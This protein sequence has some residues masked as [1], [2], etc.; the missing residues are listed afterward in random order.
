MTD[1]L[2][3]VFTRK[4]L[5]PFLR[6]TTQDIRNEIRAVA[7]LCRAGKNEYMVPVF[8]CGKLPIGDYYFIDMELC[9]YTLRQYLDDQESNTDPMVKRSAQRIE[10]ILA[11]A[12][13]TSDICQI[14]KHIANGIMYIHSQG[15]IHRDIKPKNGT[16]APNKN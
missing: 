15:K 9:D 7:R 1:F 16:L 14:L 4:I 2:L 13:K 6:I 11:A 12:I 3:Q 10:Q 5:R 8:R